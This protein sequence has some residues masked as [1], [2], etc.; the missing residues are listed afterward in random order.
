[1]YGARCLKS[2]AVP[3]TLCQHCHSGTVRLRARW[4]GA[5]TGLLRVHDENIITMRSSKGQVRHKRKSNLKGHISSISIS[6]L[7]IPNPYRALLNRKKKNPTNTENS[8]FSPLFAALHLVS[9]AKTALLDIPYIPY[10]CEGTKSWAVSECRTNTPDKGITVVTL[11][12]VTSQRA[13]FPVLCV[14]APT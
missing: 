2:G 7:S 12:L 5:D 8:I 9:V 3:W 4:A 13:Q 10:V 6:T 11:P 1:M 14:V